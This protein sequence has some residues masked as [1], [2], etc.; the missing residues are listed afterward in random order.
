VSGNQGSAVRTVLVVGTGLIGA[1]VGLALRA[2]GHSVYLRD[3]DE[4]RV[5][6]A[7]RRGAGEADAGQPPDLVVVAVPPRSAAATVW[8]QLRATP[9]CTVCD[10]ASIKVQVRSQFERLLI[11]AEGNRPASDLAARYLGSHPMAGKEVSGPEAAS[12]DLFRGRTWVLTPS[13]SS[14]S[15]ALDDARW[16][17]EECGATPLLMTADE[18]DSA[19]AFTSHLPQL[20]AS[21]LAAHALEQPQRV[22]ATAGQGLRDMIRI[23]ASDPELWV[24]ITTMNPVLAGVLRDYA[25]QLTR[26]AD[27][28]DAGGGEAEALR[29]LE[30]GRRGYARISST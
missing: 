1:S 23:A 4:E 17:V 30:A 15:R 10:T 8:E 27:A 18:H 3:V 6:E 7:E 19:V 26:L 25:A 29:V 9:D 21:I 24:Q 20:V 11:D 22:L 12:A 14:S 28:L 2:R 5:R 13:K 16:L